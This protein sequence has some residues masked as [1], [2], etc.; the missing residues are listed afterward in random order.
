[1]RDKEEG[2]QVS[3]ITKYA[4]GA[5]TAYQT[6]SMKEIADTYSGP[7]KYL[8]QRDQPLE[9]PMDCIRKLCDAIDSSYDERCDLW[10]L[11][12]FIE[13][14]ELPFGEDL[15]KQ[16]FLEA[17]SGRGFITH[18]QMNGGLTHEEIAATVR[19]RHQW[20]IQTKTWEVKYRPYRDYWIVLLLTVNPKIFA[21][22]VPKVV[23]SRIKA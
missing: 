23:P 10:E 22:P 20:N 9:I 3:N 15:A 1:M 2:D 18:K 16:M 13:K 19:G 12:A 8:K 4:K 6:V 11:K 5:Q 17:S 7:P 14:K 21:L